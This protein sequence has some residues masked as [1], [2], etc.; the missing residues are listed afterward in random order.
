HLVP[1]DLIGVARP[2]DDL[3]TPDGTGTMH[4]LLMANL[5]AQSRVLAFGRTEEE[6]R[7]DDVDPA[8]VPHKAMPGNRPSTTIFAPAL[9]PGVLGQLIALYEHVVFSQAAVLGLIAF[10]QWG[11]EPGKSQAGELLPELTA[12]KHPEQA[13]DS[14]TDSPTEI[15]REARGRR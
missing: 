6:V 5:F 10:D 4:D 7:A 15:Y 13:F 14:S 1:V 11:V 3:P 8:V 2:S 9:I 12:E